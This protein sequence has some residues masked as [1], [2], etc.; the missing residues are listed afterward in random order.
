MN[1]ARKLSLSNFMKLIRLLPT[2]PCMILYLGLSF[3]LSCTRLY[4]LT[5]FDIQHNVVFQYE[6]V[7]MIIDV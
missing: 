1:L 5:E 7:I 4:V 6:Q 2:V 3:C